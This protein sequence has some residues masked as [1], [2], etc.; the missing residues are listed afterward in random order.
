[1]ERAIC[2][3]SWSSHRIQNDGSR[4]FLF[5]LALRL[6]TRLNRLRYAARDLLNPFAS[7]SFCFLRRRQ[8]DE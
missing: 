2:P 1:M 4:A 3:V 5:P 6:T 7:V 8:I